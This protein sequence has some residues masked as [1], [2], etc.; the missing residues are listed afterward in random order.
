MLILKFYLAIISLSV[1]KTSVRL[2]LTG[3]K[4]GVLVSLILVGQ[5]LWFLVYTFQRL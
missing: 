5:K 3:L 4:S 2:S 1:H